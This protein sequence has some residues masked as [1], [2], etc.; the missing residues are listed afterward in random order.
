VER[1]SAQNIAVPTYF[2]Q[3]DNEV[4]T[5]D[6]VIEEALGEYQR[7]EEGPFHY[8]DAR[9]IVKITQTFDRAF[10]LF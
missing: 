9:A 6:E 5:K 7:A 3:V 1:I 4:D 8:L 2:E 10:R